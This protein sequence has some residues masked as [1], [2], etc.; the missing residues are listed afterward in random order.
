MAL[1]PGELAFIS[2]MVL[3]VAAFI[4]INTWTAMANHEN[5]WKALSA[6]RTIYRS[7]LL[8]VY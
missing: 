7:G 2:A 5:G 8:N 4:S 1:K 3:V 6:P